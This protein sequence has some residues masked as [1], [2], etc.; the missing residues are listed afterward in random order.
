[1]KKILIAPHFMKSSQVHRISVFSS[2][3][4]F[5][6]QEGFLPQ[7]ACFHTELNSLKTALKLADIYVE[8][9]QALILH[10]GS[11]V[12]AC[13]YKKNLKNSSFSQHLFRDYF[14]LALIQKAIEKRVPILGLCRGLQILNVYFNG[15]LKQSLG[16]HEN[17]H[18][19]A[20]EGHKSSSHNIDFMNIGKIHSIEIQKNSWLAKILKKDTILV[21]SIHTQAVDKT[22]QGLQIEAI[23]EDGTIEALSNI[24]QKIFAVQWHP[25]IDLEDSNNQKILKNWLKLV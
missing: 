14:E 5:L 9:F 21:N 7:I 17:T 12:S 10:G 8:G 24:S 1:M 19:K 13:L 2:L 6:L 22:G 11:N 25:E 18:S 23:C 16:Q 15:T 4:D 3:T 20:I